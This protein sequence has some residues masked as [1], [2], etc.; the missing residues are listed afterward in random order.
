MS[1]FVPQNPK[2]IQGKVCPPPVTIEGIG[3]RYQHQYEKCDQSGCE[4][5]L[6]ANMIDE[7]RIEMRIGLGLR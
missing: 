7:I 5:G 6:E 2:Y 3:G 1:A 4:I